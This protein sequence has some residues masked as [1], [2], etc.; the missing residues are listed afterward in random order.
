MEFIYKESTMAATP[1]TTRT[2]WDTMGEMPVPEN[3]L[4][5]AQTAR[6]VRNFPISE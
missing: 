1:G 4:Y 5:G 6:A 3:A 2:E